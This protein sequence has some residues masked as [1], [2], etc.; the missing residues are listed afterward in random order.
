[1]LLAGGDGLEAAIASLQDKVPL[2]VVTLGEEGAVA[3]V[4]GVVPDGL[5]HPCSGM[6]A[7]PQFAG[8]SPIAIAYPYT[9]CPSTSMMGDVAHFRGGGM[10]LERS[11]RAY[12]TAGIVHQL[13]DTR[14]ELKAMTYAG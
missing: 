13:V 10:K 12:G 3:R 11:L 6:A 14:E 2:L 7:Q 5:T 4:P 8:L 9:N 1:M